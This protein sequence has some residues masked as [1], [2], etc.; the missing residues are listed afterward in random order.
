[1][2]S[3]TRSSTLEI[4]TREQFS[5][6]TCVES[7]AFKKCVESEA[8]KKCL[9]S[10]AKFVTVIKNGSTHSVVLAS[11]LYDPQPQT[12]DTERRIKFQLDEAE[13]SYPNLVTA[14][15][16]AIFVARMK[17]LEAIFFQKQSS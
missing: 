3:M 6:H 9:E 15:Q 13:S 10:K 1:M 17:N 11:A 2:I 14:A 7:E 8:F 4:F 12:P 16:T 5:D